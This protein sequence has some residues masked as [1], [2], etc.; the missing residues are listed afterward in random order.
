VIGHQA[1]GMNLPPRLLARLS[2]AFEEIMPVDVVQEDVIA[3]I[4]PRLIT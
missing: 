4:P 3:L 2:Q 1:K